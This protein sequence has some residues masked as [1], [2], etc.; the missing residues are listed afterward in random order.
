MPL[1]R[2]G[3]QRRRRIYDLKLKIR[4]AFLEKQG[5]RLR[6]KKVHGSWV[7]RRHSLMSK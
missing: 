5:W 3:K 4:R 6:R 7:K 2:E 1:K